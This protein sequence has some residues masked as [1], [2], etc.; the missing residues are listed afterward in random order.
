MAGYS[1][2]IK[3][4]NL[5]I[6]SFTQIGNAMSNFTAQNIGAN[7][8]DRVK[9]GYKGGLTLI[10]ALCVPITILYLTCARVLL[11]FFMK[12]DSAV[13]MDTGLAFIRIVAPFYIVVS[14][15]LVTDGVLRGASAMKEFMITTFADLILRV[16]LA[17]I[18]S[19]KYESVG[20]WRSWPIGW[21][22]GTIISVIF[23]VSG[24]WKKILKT[25]A[26]KVETDD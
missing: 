25:D 2:V 14:T 10:Y 24:S 21:T 19:G 15:K 23:Y 6:T 5:V 9:Q 17:F 3:L 26:A 8:P 20:I 12:E 4:N 22:I 16:L 13:A 7:K 1:A 11:S 18:L